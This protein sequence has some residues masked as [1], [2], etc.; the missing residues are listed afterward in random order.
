MLLLGVAAGVL[1]L[2]FRE[3]VL[4]LLGAYAGESETV[5]D[6]VKIYGVEYDYTGTRHRDLLVLAYQD[7]IDRAG[8]L[9]YGTSM[10]DMPMDPRMDS[11]FLSI[12]FHY[13]IHF[14]KYGYLGIATFAAFAIAASI[15][16]ISAR[17]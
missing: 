5:Q 8:W 6:R 16:S 13:L 12:D 10:Q 3:Q 11:R 7:A 15:A 4:D 17:I 2:L 9:G 1:F 14:L